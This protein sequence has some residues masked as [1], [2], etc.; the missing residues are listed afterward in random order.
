MAHLQNTLL[1]HQKLFPNICFLLLYSKFK[2]N[3]K[4]MNTYLYICCNSVYTNLNSKI[5]K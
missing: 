2:N 5:H 1:N 3:F 4:N